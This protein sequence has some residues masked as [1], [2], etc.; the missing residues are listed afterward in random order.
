VR[1][2]GESRLPG[3]RAWPV[4]GQVPAFLADKL[5]FLS[6]C[7]ARYG[8]VVE[9]H[10]GA[11]TYLLNNPADIG[12]VLVD[13]H[14]NYGKSERLTSARGKRLVSS[15]VLSTSPQTHGPRRRLLRPMFHRATITRFAKTMV[16]NTRAAVG[17]WGGGEI[18]IEQEMAD[19][20]R[21]NILAALFSVD[22]RGSGA[23]LDEA[24]AIRQQY[25]EHIFGSLLPLPEYQPA[26]VNLRYRRAIRRIDEFVHDAI[27]ERRRGSDQPDDLLS[28]AL[29]DVRSTRRDPHANGPTEAI[30]R[31][32]RDVSEP[33]LGERAVLTR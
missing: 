31:A 22:A 23:R 20:T 32:G 16:R 3:P 7:S 33:L 21:R 6:E 13:N 28:M 1:A 17:A 25:L 10:I 5:G 30:Q 24:V 27:E 8:D 15:G 2:A 12:H 29:G 19:L 14:P 9:L 4:V 26:P 11:R 18:D